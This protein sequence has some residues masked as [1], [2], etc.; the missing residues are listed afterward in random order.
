MA[1][2]LRIVALLQVLDSFSMPLDIKIHIVRLV[3]KY[4]RALWNV[5][6][7]GAGSSRSA[8]KRRAKRLKSCFKCGKLLEGPHCT[9]NQT[10]SQYRHVVFF[11]DGPIRC[12]AEKSIRR[13][14]QLAISVREFDNLLEQRQRLLE[15]KLDGLTIEQQLFE[16]DH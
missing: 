5:I 12:R 15:T 16:R 9:R 13:N 11:K 4:E 14:S 1:S 2:P 8:R 3:D 10:Y 7:F 6:A